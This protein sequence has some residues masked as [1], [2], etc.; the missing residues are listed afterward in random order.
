MRLR[1][2]LSMAVMASVAASLAT[3]SPALATVRPG[4]SASGTATQLKP[5]GKMTSHTDI[6]F[7]RAAD[8]QSIL[9]KR[10]TANQDFIF[11]CDPIE[12]GIT[13]ISPIVDT[14]GNVLEY[15]ALYSLSEE[16]PIPMFMYA[17]ISMDDQTTNKVVDSG[18]DLTD[19][20]E[21]VS[22][23]SDAQ[24]PLASNFLSTYILQMVLEPGFEWLFAPPQCIGIGTEELICTFSQPTAT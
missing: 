11:F 24:L 10:A 18:S 6:G 21:E 22:E 4:H 15:Q 5:P 2:L 23:T 13:A 16:C 17:Q 3:G 9:H 1:S 12:Y 19:F 7:G 14:N 20:G 8:V